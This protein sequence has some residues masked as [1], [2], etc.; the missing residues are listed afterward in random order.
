MSRASD[1]CLIKIICGDAEQTVLPI[2]TKIH[3]NLSLLDR[4]SC[5]AYEDIYADVNLYGNGFNLPLTRGIYSP[6]FDINK[7]SIIDNVIFFL[8]WN[9]KVV[10]QIKKQHHN[11]ICVEN[12]Y[13][14]EHKHHKR[15]YVHHH[16]CNRAECSK[17]KLRWPHRF[18]FSK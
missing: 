1:S 5:Y 14:S 11:S 3:M 7:L 17:V 13:N 10:A 15:K 8:V 16:A 9:C 4:N 12:L 6:E 18:F 2:T